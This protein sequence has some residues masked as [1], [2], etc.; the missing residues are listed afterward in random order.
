MVN[1]ID[2]NLVIDVSVKLVIINSNGVIEYGEL[3]IVLDK[4]V[5]VDLLEII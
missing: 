2:E 1:S 3:L 5:L 4:F